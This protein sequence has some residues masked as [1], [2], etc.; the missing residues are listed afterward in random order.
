MRLSPIWRAP[1]GAA[2][3]LGVMLL[4]VVAVTFASAVTVI[5]AHRGAWDQYRMAGQ[6]WAEWVLALNRAPHLETRTAW[7]GGDAESVCQNLYHD[8]VS[9]ASPCTATGLPVSGLGADPNLDYGAR[10]ADEPMHFAYVEV[11]TVSGEVCW[12]P[13]TPAPTAGDRTC[14]CTGTGTPAGCAAAT[15]DCTCERAG[16]AVLRPR[17]LGRLDAIRRGATDGGLTALGVVRG[18]VLAGPDAIT[19]FEDEV[20][21]RLPSAWSTATPPAPVL[22]EG[23]LVAIAHLS[24]PYV[25]RGLHYEAPPGR[26]DLARM[27][28]GLDMD[29]NTLT[30]EGDHVEAREAKDIRDSTITFE[31]SSSSTDDNPES[32][33]KAD[34]I[35]AQSLSLTSSSLARPHEIGKRRGF[36]MNAA[37]DETLRITGS[38]TFASAE[39]NCRSMPGFVSSPVSTTPPLAAERCVLAGGTSVRR[40]EI[41]DD[42]NVKRDSG[43]GDADGSGVRAGIA[44]IKELK[45]S[46]GKCHGCTAF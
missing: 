20:E 8:P 2:A 35:V 26:P 44:N 19:A 39:T 23:D 29:G 45:I 15:P 32:A 6:T 46:T 41:G 22:E 33:V 4:S 9:T 3:L 5:H 37:Q 42:L 10:V 12:V 11:P 21:S 13:A 24:I 7:T 25:E 30:V 16:V 34:L 31:P 18:G 14:G 43:S 40:L 27:Q 28:T 38:G 17:S 1:R 36:D